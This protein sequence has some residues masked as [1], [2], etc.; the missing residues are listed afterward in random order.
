MS[1]DTL[2]H[3]WASALEKSVSCMCIAPLS[4][5]ITC[6]SQLGH[7]THTNSPCGHALYKPQ[8]KEVCMH[9]SM[10]AGFSAT[11]HRLNITD[12]QAGLGL[13]EAIDA[14]RHVRGEGVAIWTRECLVVSTSPRLGAASGTCLV[15]SRISTEAARTIY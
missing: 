5:E 15:I 14:G 4:T 3:K 8:R 7:A 13:E 12:S 10:H 11:C 2:C 1:N 6:T 9:A